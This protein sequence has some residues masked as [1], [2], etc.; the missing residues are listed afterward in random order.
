MRAWRA[1][2]NFR[3]D[4]K[5][6]T[7]MHRITVNVAWTQRR[8]QRKHRADPIDEAFSEPAAETISPERAAESAAMQGRLRTALQDPGLVDALAA[9]FGSQCVVLGVDSSLEDGVYRVLPE[10][11]VETRLARARRKLR[12]QM[13][14]D[15]RRAGATDEKDVE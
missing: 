12:Q 13:S 10:T 3:G 14:D 9:R 5:F 8:K 2:P 11:T 4:A 1:L 6:S 7:W 15:R